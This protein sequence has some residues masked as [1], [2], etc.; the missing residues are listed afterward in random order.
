MVVE[1]PMIPRAILIALGLAVFAHAQQSMR[2][3]AIQIVAMD[4]VQEQ[5]L[6]KRIPI[7]EGDIVTDSDLVRTAKAIAAFDRGLSFKIGDPDGSGE[8]VIRISG[9]GW[10][11]A[12]YH[13]PARLK[14]RVE[15]VYPAEARQQHV[16]GLVRVDFVVGSDG[17][18]HDPKAEGHAL[19]VDAAIAAV[20]QWVYDP[21]RANGEPKEITL[22]DHFIFDL[23]DG[24]FFDPPQQRPAV[25]KQP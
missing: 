24:T 14:S 12:V 9:A 4:D 16:Q 3:K 22:S 5:K 17:L 19:L 6:R 13:Q 11:P 8:A 21:E 15:P 25:K 7:H 10:G 2:V 20:K 1:T 23:K 18:V